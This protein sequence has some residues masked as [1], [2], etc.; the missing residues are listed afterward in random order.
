MLSSAKSVQKQ[1]P[2]ETIIIVDK[3]T[4]YRQAEQ[5]AHEANIAKKPPIEYNVR[6]DNG[7][8]TT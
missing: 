2:P 7:Q 8:K 3:K 1:L 6:L 5:A 4:T